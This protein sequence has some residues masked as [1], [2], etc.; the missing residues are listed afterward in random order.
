MAE[1]KRTYAILAA[2]LEEIVAY[3]KRD[4]S[5]FAHRTL[6]RTHFALVEGLTFQLIQLALAGGKDDPGLF[7][8]EEM[9][10]LRQEKYE[11]SNTGKP[12][13]R[14]VFHDLLPSIRFAIGCF[15][16][17]YG[18]Q[19]HPEYSTPGWQ[20]MGKLR[21][22]RNRVTHPRNTED[23]HLSDDDLR[24]A[25]AAAGWFKTTMTSLFEACAQADENLRQK[26]DA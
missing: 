2:D 5:E 26:G 15:S 19:F 8:A 7:S 18:A 13:S 24:Y 22:I 20:A 11:L 16:Q 14:T 10:V 21:L 4:P 9:G 6:V 23:L 25:T 12:K 17:V 1:L 3:G